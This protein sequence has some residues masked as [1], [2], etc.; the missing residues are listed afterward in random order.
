V[1]NVE[2]DL[3]FTCTTRDLA[4]QPGPV[5]RLQLQALQPTLNFW[6][7]PRELHA[8]TLNTNK[9]LPGRNFTCSFA[10]TC[11]SIPDS[12]PVANMSLGGQGPPM[13]IVLKEGSKRREKAAVPR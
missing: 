9:R 11:T 12:S 1:L 10:S 2:L 4:S 7:G 8:S 13:I 3:V 5:P 6:R